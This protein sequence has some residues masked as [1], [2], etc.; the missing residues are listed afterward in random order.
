MRNTFDKDALQA[1]LAYARWLHQKQFRDWLNEKA[2]EVGLPPQP[3]TICLNS[4]G[5]A[6]YSQIRA[7]LIAKRDKRAGVLLIEGER[8]AVV[9]EILTRMHG[10]K[11]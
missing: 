6:V 7:D 10:G 3:H 1:G 5:E 9:D 11:K 2:A 4:V 8:R